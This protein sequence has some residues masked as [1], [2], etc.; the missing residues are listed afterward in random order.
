MLEANFDN[1]PFLVLRKT[2]ALVV[3]SSLVILRQTEA[4]VRRCSSK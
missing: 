3:L 1:D 4:A 2:E